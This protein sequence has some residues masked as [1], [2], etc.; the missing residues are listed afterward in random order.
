MIFNNIYET[1]GSTPMVRLNRMTNENMAEVL[2]KLESFNPGSSVKDRIALSMIQKAEELGLLK[3]DSVIIEP[4]SGN[5][6]IGLAMVGAAKGY[7]VILVMPETMSIERRKLMK[8]YGAELILTDGKKG[9]RGA[10]EEAERLAKEYGYFMPQQFKNLANPEIHMKTTAIEILEQTQGKI[11]VFVAGVG[12]GGTITGVGQILKRELPNI[13]IIAVEPADSP[14]L[15]GGNPGPHKIQGIGAG[16][17][18]DILDRNVID[19]IVT[20]KALDAFETSRNLAKREGILVG[21]SSGAAIF[22]AL[23]K[24][25]EIGSGKRVVTVAPDTGERYLSTE[26]FEE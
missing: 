14:V 13:K 21:I 22:V 16:F 18:P 6:G 17:I 3:T 4:T 15:S 26:L 8:A 9:M 1:I 25:M 23:N 24:A 2:V 19:E 11:D 20:V 10:V 12:T 7:R 5:T